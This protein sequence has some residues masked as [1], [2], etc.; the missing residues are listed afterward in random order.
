MTKIPLI[1][2]VLLPFISHAQFTKG[3]K[4]IG[5]SLQYTSNRNTNAESKSYAISVL[6]KVG[7]L[8]NEKWAIGAMLGYQNYHTKHAG[9]VN[10]ESFGAGFFTRRY[11]TISEKFIFSLE[12]GLSYW[13]RETWGS[14][15]ENPKYDV[16]SAT[17]TPSFLF[18]PSSH[19]GI[20]L[21]LASLVYDYTTYKDADAPIHNFSVQAGALNLGLAYYFRK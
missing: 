17:I 6:P 14:F 7:F 9:I 1:V 16:A 13:N 20:E 3:D 12:G 19:W 11:F 21:S 15:Y 5:G 8:L 10:S 2:L 4:F 18:F